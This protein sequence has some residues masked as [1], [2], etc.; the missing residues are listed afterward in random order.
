VAFHAA[1]IAQGALE[2]PAPPGP[3]MKT[4]DEVE[5]RIPVS[6]AMV[7]NQPGSYFLSSNI[8]GTFNI[9]AENVSLDLNG[10][11]ITPES[12]VAIRVSFS[13]NVRIFNGAIVGGEGSGIGGREMGS[14]FI[15]DLQLLDITGAC[16]ELNDPSG[17]LVI[18]R[19]R[20]HNATRA[21][22]IMRQGEDQ[23]FRVVIRDNVISNVN[24]TTAVTTYGIG[25]F[26]NA[27][28]ELHAVVTGNQILDNRTL[29]LEVRGL[30]ATASGQVTGNL[31]SGNGSIGLTVRA[32]VVVA[33]NVASSN[34][35]NYS[36]TSPQAAP[37]TALDQ[38]PGPWDNISE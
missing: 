35:T 26:H 15:S 36:V 3:T 31:I 5:P 18:E 9:L 10:F 13:D 38:N 33:K 29:G 25:V 28:A 30:Q 12:A 20:C 4:L 11:T 8:T 34:G 17:I 6:E 27:T 2:P 37:I 21:G 24:T 19:I 16:I 1:A 14:V 23:P 22:I 7:I 32:D